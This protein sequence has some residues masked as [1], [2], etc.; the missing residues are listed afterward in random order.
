MTTPVEWA[1]YPNFTPKELACKHCG[2]QGIQSEMMDVLQGIRGDLDKTMFISS[3]YRCPKHPV[4]QEKQKP[5]EHS[6]GLAVDIIC[7][8][9][10]ALNIIFYAQSF[11]V[12]RIGIHQKGNVNGRFVHIGIADRYNLEFPAAIWTY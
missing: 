5:G 8:G 6:L 1:K 3:G 2:A 11:G 10:N 12:K 7:H 9:V 4:E